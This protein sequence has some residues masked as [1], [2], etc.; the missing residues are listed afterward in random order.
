MGVFFML[1]AWLLLL[2]MVLIFSYT[3]Q[4]ECVLERFWILIPRLVGADESSRHEHCD[5]SLVT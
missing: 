1:I 4:D 5:W 3:L 2:V